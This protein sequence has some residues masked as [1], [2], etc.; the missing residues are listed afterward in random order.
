MRNWL[1]SV[2]LL[3]LLTLPVWAQSTQRYWYRGLWDGWVEVKQAPASG[4]YYRPCPDPAIPLNEAAYGQP[5][6]CPKCG[7]SHWAG[8]SRCAVCGGQCTAGGN[9]E[10]ESTVYTSRRLPGMYFY[11]QQPHF[12]W[13]SPIR[14][15]A[16]YQRYTH[17][18][19]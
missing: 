18:T 3:V 15:G 6:P 2:P 5:I 7:H 13:A 19:D 12:N 17:R 1:V 14:V 11:E 10:P 16:D 4:Y 9:R 8:E